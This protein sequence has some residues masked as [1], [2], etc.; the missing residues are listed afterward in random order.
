FHAHTGRDAV[1]CG[2]GD[3]AMRSRALIGPRIGEALAQMT[4]KSDQREPLLPQY[5]AL[6]LTGDEAFR[7]K[8]LMKVG[9][10]LADAMKA[11]SR[12]PYTE[13]RPVHRP[14]VRQD[15]VRVDHDRD[16]SARERF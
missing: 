6:T 16:A 10:D 7:P 15:D 5:P 1:C 8:P 12:H 4:E 14:G 3:E 13:V 2:P 9:D 11:V